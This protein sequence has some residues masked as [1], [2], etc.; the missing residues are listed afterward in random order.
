V[1]H[2]P[3]ELFRAATA[4]GMRALGWDGGELKAGML[5]DFITIQPPQVEARKNLDLGYLMFCCSAADV[6]NVVVGGK[7]VVAT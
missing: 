2:Q 6:V 5:A 1:H 4:G 3:D 7:T